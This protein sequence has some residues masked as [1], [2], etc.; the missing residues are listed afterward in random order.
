MLAKF[1]CIKFLIAYNS[2]ILYVDFPENNPTCNTNMSAIGYIGANRCDI[3][4]DI[5][6]ISCS[7][8]YSGNIP[9]VLQW[10]NEFSSRPMV[11][12]SQVARMTS[13]DF[14]L[15]SL[16]KSADTERASES[17]YTCYA[18]STFAIVSPERKLKQ[19]SY[20]CKSGPLRIIGKKS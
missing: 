1:S 16:L 6:N 7:V 12:E 11:L 5:M 9:P 17:S 19:Q 8:R 10:R 3:E 18:D 13:N 4:P 20:S 15:A 2:R 14:A